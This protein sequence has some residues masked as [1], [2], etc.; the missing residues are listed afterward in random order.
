MLWSVARNETRARIVL[1]F[2]C[3]IT[4]VFQLGTRSVLRGTLGLMLSFSV[5]L[6]RAPSHPGRRAQNHQ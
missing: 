4:D 2:C 3:F 5:S 6:S 1:R